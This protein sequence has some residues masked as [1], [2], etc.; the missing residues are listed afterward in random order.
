MNSVFGNTLA[1]YHYAKLSRLFFFFFLT[2]K[3]NNTEKSCG[4]LKV[5]KHQTNSTGNIKM[6]I[7][8]GKW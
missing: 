6:K 5:P 7:E 3:Q 1:D 8:K 4:F 2:V